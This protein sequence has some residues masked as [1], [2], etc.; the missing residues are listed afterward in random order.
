MLAAKLIQLIETHAGGL[1]REAL[2]DLMT[3]PRTQAFKLVGRDELEARVCALYRNLG[4]WIGDPSDDAVRTEYEA[5]G[6]RRYQEG[7]PL[8]EIV[9]AVIVTKRHL[10]RFVR[11]HGLV[12]PSS[13]RAEWG[14]LLPVHLQGLQ[15]LNELVGDFFDRAMYYL[16][17]GYEV[18]ASQ[19][20]TAVSP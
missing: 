17:R 8:S 18:A 6:S 16:A 5:W 20:R 14:E 15:E 10:S 11:D 12:E 3:N 19:T 9:Y 4:D 7:I 1:T 13:D 2:T